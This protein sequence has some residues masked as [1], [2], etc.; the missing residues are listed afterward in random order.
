[1]KHGKS[2]LMLFCCSL[3]V[4]GQQGEIFLLGGVYNDYGMGFKTPAPLIGARALIQTNRVE[5]ENIFWASSANKN[6]TNDGW[7]SWGQAMTFFKVKELFAFGPGIMVR[8]TDTSGWE[9]TSIYPS[10]GISKKIKSIELRA[11]THLRDQWTQNHGRGGTVSVAT[12]GDGRFQI[13]GAVT[14]MR[15]ATLPSD[16]DPYAGA[17]VCWAGYSFYKK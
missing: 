10:F 11:V 2:A 9:K 16:L 5:F 13:G 17:M 3:V 12:S 8:H 6:I 7:T 15:F 4:Y 1:M 14:W